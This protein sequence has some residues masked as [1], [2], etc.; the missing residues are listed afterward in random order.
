MRHWRLE[1][2]RG[3]ICQSNDMYTYFNFGRVRVGNIL[4]NIK[5]IILKWSYYIYHRNILSSAGD[6]HLW[7]QGC[8]TDDPYDR[9]L[10]VEAAPD[11]GVTVTSCLQACRDMPGVYQF[12]A[13]LVNSHNP[14]NTKHLYNICT[15]LDQRRRRWVDVV[16]MLY[17]C[18][19]FAGNRHII[20]EFCTRD[21]QT[22]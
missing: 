1:G 14:A 4:Y 13:L 7:Q 20:W 5:K 9:D 21:L 6:T 17:K 2:W 15:M 19:V 11:G 3:R 8:Y 12:V 16:Q 10:S 18:F 22:L